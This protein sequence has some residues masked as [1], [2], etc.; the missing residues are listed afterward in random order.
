MTF[1]RAI[2]GF[3]VLLAVT[4]AQAQLPSP[5]VNTLFANTI[6][7]TGTGALFTTTGTMDTQL[8]GFSD[9]GASAAVFQ[10]DL[11]YD[12]PAVTI[13]RTRSSGSVMAASPLLLI[14]DGPEA[15]GTTAVV[16]IG[17]CLTLSG[18]NWTTFWGN[19]SESIPGGIGDGTWK[20]APGQL[21]VDP[22]HRQLLNSSGTVMLNYSGTTLTAGP[23]VTISQAMLPPGAVVHYRAVPANCTAAGNPGDFSFDATHVYI[24]TGN[25]VTHSWLKIVGVSS[26]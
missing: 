13:N 24:Y 10:Q 7:G 11:R 18:D 16:Q 15:T 20:Y 23:G 26:F 22:V 17:G 2:F 3:L 5:K 19:G 25:G 1:S 9:N 6:Q 21:S 14:Q 12:S 8:V 4:E